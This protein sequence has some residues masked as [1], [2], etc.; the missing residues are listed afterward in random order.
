MRVRCLQIIGHRTRRLAEGAF[1]ERLATS[2]IWRVSSWEGGLWGPV[3][4]QCGIATALRPVRI[5]RRFRWSLRTARLP[6]FSTTR[7]GIVPFRRSVL[8]CLPQG[9]FFS[10][11]TSAYCAALAFPDFEA[12]EPGGKRRGMALVYRR[13]SVPLSRGDLRQFRQRKSLRFPELRSRW[14]KVSGA[15]SG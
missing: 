6:P 3:E 1:L 12:S 7:T 8:R 2:L 5:L 14:R 11:K 10:W 15:A 4:V 13:F 9:G